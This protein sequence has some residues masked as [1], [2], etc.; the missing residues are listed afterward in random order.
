MN[1]EALRK[2]IADAY[3]QLGQAL[4]AFEHAPQG[5]F[6]ADD[7]IDIIGNLVDF[8]IMQ[9]AERDGDLFDEVLSRFLSCPSVKQ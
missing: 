3:I 5:T 1:K 7:D 4:R 9:N 8:W 6:D 2:Q